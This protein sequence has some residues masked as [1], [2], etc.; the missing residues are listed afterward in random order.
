[1]LDPDQIV[2]DFFRSSNAHDI[3]GVAA[4]YALNGAHEDVATKHRREGRS[5][6]AEGLGRFLEALP[7]A[8][9][10][11]QHRVLAGPSVV[12]LYTLTG[13]L[14]GALG[15]FQPRGQRIELTGAHVFTLGDAGIELTRDYWDPKEF[16]RQASQP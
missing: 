5:S 15:P 11:G 12:V 10:D 1:M 8:H 4:L 6:I 3:E 16:A 7:D 2:N 13:H 14:N 9:W